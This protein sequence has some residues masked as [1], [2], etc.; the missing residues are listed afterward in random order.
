MF[1]QRTQGGYRTLMEGIEMKA[2]VHGEKTLMTEFFL[3]KGYT[4]PLHS[5]PHE[6][7]G[8]LVKGHLRFNVAGEHDDGDVGMDIANPPDK[9]HAGHARH[10]MVGD[11]QIELDL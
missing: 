4:L 10:A 2:L 8:Y 6:Q 3:H 11:D 7:T 5:H 9:L 1:S